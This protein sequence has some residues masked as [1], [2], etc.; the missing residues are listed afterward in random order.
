MNREG[1]DESGGTEYKGT[2]SSP[3][4]PIRVSLD[5]FYRLIES[6]LAIACLN[7]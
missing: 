2:L 5:E 7:Q 4:N 6:G 1:C 3:T